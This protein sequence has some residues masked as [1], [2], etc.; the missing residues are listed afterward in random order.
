VANGTPDS[1]KASYI[2]G[3]VENGFVGIGYILADLPNCSVWWCEG[4]Y[5]ISQKRALPKAKAKEAHISAARNEYEPFQIV[6]HPKVP[7]FDVKVSVSPLE[8]GEEPAPSTGSRQALS[9][10][11][12]RSPQSGPRTLR[13]R[14][15]S[16][17][18][19]SDDAKRRFWFSGRLP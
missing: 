9:K 13:W 16:I 6:L 19:T 17:Y 4:T 7:F 5:K 12:G 15:S 11:K 1:G 8:K 2:S 14:L 10:A 18:R 3:K